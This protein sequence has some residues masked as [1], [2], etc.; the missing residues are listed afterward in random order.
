M[1][2]EKLLSVSG[3]VI[4]TACK[5][6]NTHLRC[7]IIKKDILQNV[8]KFTGRQLCQ[9]LC[10]PETWNFIKKETLSQVRS[11]KISEIFKNTFFTEHLQANASVSGSSS[12]THMVIGICDP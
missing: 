5:W 10:R 1:P 6:R 2:A 4:Y 8:A 3:F 7:F 11:Y 12:S 9:S